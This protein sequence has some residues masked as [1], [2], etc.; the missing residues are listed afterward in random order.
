MIGR[1]AMITGYIR[2]LVRR[3]VLTLVLG[4]AAAFHV[5]AAELKGYG[6]VGRCPEKQQI[7][8][9][10]KAVVTPPKGWIEDEDWGFRYRNLFLFENG[11]QSTNKPLM[12]LQAQPAGKDDTLEK[13][14]ENVEKSW[15]A[16]NPDNTIERLADF[17]RKNKPAFKVFLYRNPS[18]PEQAFE[19]TAFTRDVD[20]ANPERTYTFQAVLVSPD[21][22]ELERTKAAFYELLAN[23]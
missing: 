13:Y 21:E 2:A 8:F 7:C 22:K 9:W 20:A 1:V 16:S 4:S 18:N 11:D 23:L 15:K 17:E 14:I 5:S 6:A 3:S 19:L 12:Y 10:V